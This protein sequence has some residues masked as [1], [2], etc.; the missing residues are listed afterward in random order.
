MKYKFDLKGS[1]VNRRVG[2]D[3][4]KTVNYEIR[5]RHKKKSLTLDIFKNEMEQENRKANIKLPIY[6]SVLKDMNFIE[7]K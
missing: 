3:A 6:K 1:F 4:Q 5:R 7:V 2:F